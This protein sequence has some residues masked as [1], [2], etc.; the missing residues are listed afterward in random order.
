MQATKKFQFSLCFELLPEC[1][2]FKSSD[3][4]FLG[5]PTKKLL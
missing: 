2:G 1:P 5:L 4:P 3:L